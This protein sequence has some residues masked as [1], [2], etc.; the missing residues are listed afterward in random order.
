MNLRHARSAGRL[1]SGVSTTRRHVRV[2]TVGVVIACMLGI[3]P[4]ASAAFKPLFT[5]ASNAPGTVTVSYSQASSND[6]AAKLEFHAPPG[7][8]AK[9]STKVGA[10]VGTA[11]ANAAAADIRG[12]TVPL[13]GTVR[14]AASTTP[15]TTGG[16]VG[17]AARACAGSSASTFWIVTLKGFNQ[18]IPL[19]IAVQ[20][21]SA[22]SAAGGVAL[23]ICPPPADVPNGAA[24]RAQLGLKIVQLTLKFTNVFTVPPGTHTWHLR[25][26]PYSPA[27]SVV[28][29]VAATEAEAQHGLPQQL[30][31]AATPA[32]GS[33]RSEVSGRLTL[34]GKGVAGRTIRILA[35]G[36]QIGTAE[37]NASGAFETT[38]ALGRAPA[39]LTAKVVVP[40]RYLSPCAHPAFAPIPCTSSIV[41]GFSASSDRVRVES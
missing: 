38:V 14:V 22:G 34:A 8:A 39:T 2:S 16:T 1:K 27:S 29:T 32:A 5:A 23:S 28:N 36:K 40:A 11:T 12:A 7:Y 24:G 35:G 4:S 30:T 9:L 33:N 15:L 25:A 13:E 3:A 37:T 21:V 17:D 6:G 19:A 20:P 10:V 41:A 26:T 18:T 31:L